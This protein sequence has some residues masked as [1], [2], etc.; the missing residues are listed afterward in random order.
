MNPVLMLAARNEPLPEDEGKVIFTASTL[1]HS[2]V[3]RR[4]GPGW[5]ELTNNV[6]GPFRVERDHKLVA[7]VWESWIS[8]YEV[9]KKGNKSASYSRIHIM[10]P[11]SE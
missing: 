11:R 5:L 3:C 9:P 4:R 8:I 7:A 6:E 10:L 1:P 2:E